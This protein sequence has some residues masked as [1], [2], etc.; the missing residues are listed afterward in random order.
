MFGP[1]ASFLT[2]LFLA[3]ILGPSAAHMHQFVQ[4]FIASW[5]D[6]ALVPNFSSSALLFVHLVHGTSPLV[7]LVCKE[8]LT[9]GNCGPVGPT[10]ATLTLP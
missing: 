1:G 4:R 8:I 7:Y 6:I 10:H 2:F 3:C 9:I 5:E